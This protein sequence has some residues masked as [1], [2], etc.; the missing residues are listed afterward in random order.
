MRTRLRVVIDG[1]DV[2]IDHSDG[3]DTFIDTIHRIGI[4]EVRDLKIEA[5]MPPYTKRVLPL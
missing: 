1:L 3:S 4:E 5:K 2:V